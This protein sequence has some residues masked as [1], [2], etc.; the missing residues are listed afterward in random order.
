MLDSPKI[1]SH[2]TL[3]LLVLRIVTPSVIDASEVVAAVNID[4]DVLIGVEEAVS[5]LVLREFG[6]SSSELTSLISLLVFLSVAALM[7]VLVAMPD[8]L[9][10]M[11]CTIPLL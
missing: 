4:D 6:A 10:C 7:K 3:N 9:D 5:M 8:E 11:V 2:P 1:P